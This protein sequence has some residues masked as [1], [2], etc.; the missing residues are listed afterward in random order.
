MTDPNQEDEVSRAA[1]FSTFADAFNKYPNA[2]TF[3]GSAL[4]FGF[5]LP[6]DSVNAVNAYYDDKQDWEEEPEPQPEPTVEQPEEMPTKFVPSI[7]QVREMELWQTFA[8][9][10]HKKSQPLDFPFEVR[11]LPADVAEQIRARLSIADSE[12][13]IKAAFVV[14]EQP[15]SELSALI[16]ALN[17][18]K[19]A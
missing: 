14:D 18:F 11:T 9:R 8:F 2:E 7:E 12:D 1:A 16:D 10:K 3:L 4:A 17:N 6:D 5:E 19:V 15:K 13:T